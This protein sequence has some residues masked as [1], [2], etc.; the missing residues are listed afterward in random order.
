[1]DYNL[2]KKEGTLNR[3]GVIKIVLTRIEYLSIGIS[4]PKGIG[5]VEYICFKTDNHRLVRQAQSLH[6]VGCRTHDKCLAR[7]HLMIADAASV[8]LQ[9]P[10]GILLTLVEVGNA[11][12]FE[13]KVGKSL[14]RAVEVGSHKTVEKTV[15]MVGELLLERVGGPSEPIN[16]A[17]SDFLN[18]YY[19]NK[20]IRLLGQ[21]L[22]FATFVI[23]FIKKNPTDYQLSFSLPTTPFLIASSILSI[24]TLE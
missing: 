12:P 3:I 10:H 2:S 21:M 7:S 23:K 1:M 24:I 8:G 22:E 20:S 19:N 11:Q 9:H 14:V 16:K 4:F 18:L 17:L 15:V 13:V 5:N 6:L